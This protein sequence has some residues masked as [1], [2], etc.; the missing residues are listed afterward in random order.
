[1][2]HVTLTVIGAHLKN[3][4]LSVAKKALNLRHKLQFQNMKQSTT[5]PIFLSILPH[6]Q[7][8]YESENQTE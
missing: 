1:M 4:A 5:I 8:W 3:I 2:V 7:Q 6:K